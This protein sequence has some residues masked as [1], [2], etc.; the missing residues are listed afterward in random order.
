L[1]IIANENIKAQNVRVI[2]EDG[3]NLGIF[4]LNE[5]IAMAQERE[6]DLVLLGNQATSTTC[7]ITDKARYIYELKQKEKKQKKNQKAKET[8][9][10][11]ISPTIASNDLH[12]KEHSAVRILQEGDDVR[13][14][15]QFRG[16]AIAYA[17]TQCALLD[18]FADDIADSWTKRTDIKMKGKMAFIVLKS[19][20]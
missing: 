6:L 2:D 14:V 12:V 8:K 3:T 9:E 20:A 16:R 18:Q 4:P 17:K 15:M 11:R 19:K 7:K 5:A 13:V 1:T 10:I